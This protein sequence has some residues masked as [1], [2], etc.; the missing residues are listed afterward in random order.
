MRVYM[1]VASVHVGSTYDEQVTAAKVVKNRLRVKKKLIA[2]VKGQPVELGRTTDELRHA[3]L[4][5][6]RDKDW[7]LND[8]FAM[9]LKAE[10]KQ[11]NRETL[12]DEAVS[13]DVSYTLCLG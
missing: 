13:V 6:L 4:A 2:I 7:S 9:L 11:V 5:Y 8:F 10:K 1:Y 12:K 3:L